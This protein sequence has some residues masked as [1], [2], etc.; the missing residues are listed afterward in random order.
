MIWFGIMKYHTIFESDWSL[1]ENMMIWQIC[2]VIKEKPSRECWFPHHGK[3]PGSVMRIS[4]SLHLKDNILSSCHDLIH[5][6]I[7]SS[8]HLSSCYKKCWF[9]HHGTLP[10]SVMRIWIN[11]MTVIVITMTMIIVKSYETNMCKLHIQSQV[12]PTK[13]PHLK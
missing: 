7:S 3:L 1:I 10:G 6:I 4:I 5:H 8:Y 9:P 2:L 12:F 11:M 13:E